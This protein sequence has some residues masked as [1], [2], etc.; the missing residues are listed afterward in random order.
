LAVNTESPRAN[1]AFPG[2]DLREAV[3]TLDRALDALFGL[4]PPVATRL[5]VRL[6]HLR[7]VLAADPKT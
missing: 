7:R 5:L 1:A 6:N 2:A 3:N 4:L